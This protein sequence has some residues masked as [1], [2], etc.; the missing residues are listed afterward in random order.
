[1]Y[2][3]MQMPLERLIG[4]Q[5]ASNTTY[6]HT[7]TIFY[8]YFRQHGTFH[9]DATQHQSHFAWRYSPTVLPKQQRRCSAPHCLIYRSVSKQK[10]IQWHHHVNM[11]W[12]WRRR[13]SLSFFPT[14]GIGWI[15]VSPA[16][17]SSAP[18][19]LRR[20][21]GYLVYWELGGFWNL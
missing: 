6:T 12:H 21:A 7:F 4:R 14:F 18:L 5:Q 16:L 15:F 3:Y 13:F 10:R 20:L 8:R 1:M 17:I 9:Q 2:L 11:A 19:G